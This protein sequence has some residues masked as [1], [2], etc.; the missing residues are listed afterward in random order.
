LRF[1]ALQ[2][3]KTPLNIEAPTALDDI[4]VGPIF[5]SPKP[6]KEL[7]SGANIAVTVIEDGTGRPIRRST[8]RGSSQNLRRA[9]FIPARRVAT[10]ASIR[11]AMSSLMMSQS[12]SQ[13]F[14]SGE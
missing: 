8:V 14:N 1:A 9:A 10:V 7:L 5:L 13:G 12:C 6:A 3:S 2:H 11:L 4:E